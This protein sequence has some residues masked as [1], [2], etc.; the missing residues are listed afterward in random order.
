MFKH[1]RESHPEVTNPKDIFAIQ[2]IK[3]HKTAF[4]REIH[5][6]ILI[7]NFTGT[8]LNSKK[9]YVQCLIPRLEAQSVRQWLTPKQADGN[10]P[11]RDQDKEI[12]DIFEETEKEFRE[13]ID[14]MDRRAIDNLENE[15]KEAVETEETTDKSTEEK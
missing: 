11:D 15:E 2:L 9:E 10:L 8:L 13:V 7:R 5:E 3:S 1:S 6:A 4:L 12:N 14:D